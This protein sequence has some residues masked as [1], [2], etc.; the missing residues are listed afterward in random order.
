MAE[1]PDPDL[2]KKAKVINT[3]ILFS[4]VQQSPTSASHQSNQETQRS[5]EDKQTRS[6][7]ESKLWYPRMRNKLQSWIC[8]MRGEEFQLRVK[9]TEGTVHSLFLV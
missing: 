2:E 4:T 7:T 3:L 8:L 9:A 6:S 5:R 1:A